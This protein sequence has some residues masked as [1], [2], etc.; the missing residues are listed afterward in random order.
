MSARLYLMLGYP[1]AGK[2]TTAELLSE[3]TGAVS[4]SSDTFRFK[5]FEQ[6]TFSQA[7]H[8]T[9]YRTLDYM[10][11]LLLSQG[12]SVVYDANLN[13]YQHRKDKY[14]ICKR[15]GATPVLL[16]LQTPRELSKERAVHEDRSHFAPQD[17]SLE[18]MFERIVDVFEG[19]REGEVPISLDGTHVTKDSLRELLANEQLS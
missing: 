12:V 17:E 13:R 19:P 5:M 1:G 11:E 16:W 8:N 9:L 2:T 4:L 7:E 18:N 15:V 10:T 6:P 14:D 3:V